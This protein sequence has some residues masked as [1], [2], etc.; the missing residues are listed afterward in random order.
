[1]REKLKTARKGIFFTVLALV[2]FGG[3][4][5]VASAVGQPNGNTVFACVGNGG[6]LAYLQFRP[7]AD[8]NCNDGPNGLH[9]WSW[10]SQAAPAPVE[11]KVYTKFHAGPTVVAKLGG[12][13]NTG[14]TTLNATLKDLPVGDYLFEVD[15]AFV[16][17]TDAEYPEVKTYPQLSL[18]FDKNDDGRLT[19]VGADSDANEGS[20]SPNAE[21]PTVKNRHIT[22]SGSIVQRV[23]ANER[24][25]GLTAFGYN[26]DESSKRSG[27]LTLQYATITATPVGR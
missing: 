14:Q 1:M 5:G 7:N 4:V 22:V 18:F 20:I 10:R 9:R 2:L 24:N 23:N 27:E 11:Q 15:G 13:I 6:K 21:M 17:D 25:V 26:S 16:A 8:P 12:S 3:G 19:Y